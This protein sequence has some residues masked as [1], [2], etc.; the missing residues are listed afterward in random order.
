MYMPVDYY[1]DTCDLPPA[2]WRTYASTLPDVPEPEPSED[3]AENEFTTA[4]S[5]PSDRSKVAS[6]SFKKVTGTATGPGTETGS[7]HVALAKVL[8]ESEC[9]WWSVAAKRFIRSSCL[10]PRWNEARGTAEWV[11]KVGARLPAGRYRVMSIGTWADE[12]E[13]CCERGRNLIAFRLTR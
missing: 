1:G 9:A 13:M 6:R 8:S 2:D 5:S 3:P 4:I 7:V 12:A 10:D 11:I